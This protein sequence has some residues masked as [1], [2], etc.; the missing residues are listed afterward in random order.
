M[1]NHQTT[2][3][4]EIRDLLK[5]QNALIADIKAMNVETMG[6]SLLAMNQA[7]ELQA[8]NADA[9]KYARRENRKTFI[10]FVLFLLLMAGFAFYRYGSLSR[11]LG[12]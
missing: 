4:S 2:L 1:D 3:L 7:S 9:L 6:R 11:M 10:V 8:S 12:A 5:E